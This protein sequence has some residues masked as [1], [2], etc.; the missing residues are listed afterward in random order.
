MLSLLKSVFVF[1]SQLSFCLPFHLARFDLNL[2]LFLL[3]VI[4]LSNLT[5]VG[6]LV[7][8]KNVW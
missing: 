2:G 7:W 6:Y 1:V 5:S 4:V 8:I 3:F